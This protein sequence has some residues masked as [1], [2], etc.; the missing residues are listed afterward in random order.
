MLRNLKNKKLEAISKG[1]LVTFLFFQNL[2]DININY[3]KHN[4]IRNTNIVMKDGEETIPQKN[5]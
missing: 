3:V 4:E 1:I 2:P 5:P